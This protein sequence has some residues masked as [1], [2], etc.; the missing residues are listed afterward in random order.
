MA[1]FGASGTC[2]QVMLDLVYQARG[3]VEFSGYVADDFGSRV[4]ADGNP[5]LLLEEVA[6][7]ARA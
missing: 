4:H 2:V 1:C 3:E 5:V 7:W 6:E